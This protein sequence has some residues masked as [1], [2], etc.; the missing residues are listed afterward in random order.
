MIS[1]ESTGSSPPPTSDRVPGLMLVLTVL[2]L[3][4]LG[5]GVARCAGARARGPLER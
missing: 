2:A 1:R 5:E 3:N 4:V